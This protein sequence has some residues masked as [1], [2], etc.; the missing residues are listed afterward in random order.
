VT[1]GSA[2]ERSSRPR[3]SPVTS[4]GAGG[5]AGLAG[6]EGAGRRCGREEEVEEEGGASKGLREPLLGRG[7]SGGALKEPSVGGRQ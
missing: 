3:R 2:S 6:T 4:E 7:G 5:G 1:V